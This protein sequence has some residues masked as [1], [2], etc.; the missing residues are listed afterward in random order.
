M[1]FSKPLGIIKG[2]PGRIKG[3]FSALF[4]AIREFKLPKLNVQKPDFSKLWDKIRGLKETAFDFINSLLDR[5]PEGKKRPFLISLGGLG[6]LLIIIL[7]I[8]IAKPGS[9]RS[10]SASPMA[11][12]F[13]I[14]Q[15]ELFLPS[16]PD[17]VPE[18]LLEREPRK[19]WLLEDIRPYWKSPEISGL[20]REEIKSAVDKLMEGVP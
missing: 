1:D 12:G 7:V 8:I 13:V 10:N 2:I 9:N 20:W 4:S 5:L 18:F 3:F 15:E 16:E 17:F 14:P 6:A 11:K 19:I